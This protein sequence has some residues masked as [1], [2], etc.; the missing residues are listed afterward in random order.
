MLP[1]VVDAHVHQLTGV[2]GAAAQLRSSSGVGGAAGEV[3]AHLV[4]SHAPGETH[5]AVHGMPGKTQI[6]IVK[7][8]LL[9]HKALAESRLL[10]RAAKD[11]YR[12]RQSRLL[13]KLFHDQGGPHGSRP[14]GAVAAAVAVVLALDGTALCHPCFLA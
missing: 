6:Q 1:Q 3:K 2:Q 10:R 13:Q 7:A 14:Q 4:V 11:F 5:I 9:Y 8:V 12:S